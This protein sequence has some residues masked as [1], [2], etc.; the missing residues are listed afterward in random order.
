MPR[1]RRVLRRRSID[2]DH[3][4][5]D[6]VVS[7]FINMMMW[8]GKKARTTNIVYSAFDDLKSKGE[9]PVRVFKKA[10]DNVKPDIEVRS[11]RVGGANYQVPMEVRPERKLSLSCRWLIESARA[12]IGRSMEEKLSAE[13]YEASQGRGGAMRKREEV[14]KMAEANRAFAHFRW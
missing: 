9:D 13:F 7:K 5:N 11:R 12:R 8:D 2:P 6:V 1:R 14:H 4:N 3:R 10:I